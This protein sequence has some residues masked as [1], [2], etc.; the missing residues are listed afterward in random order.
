MFEI[1]QDMEHGN[2]L[3]EYDIESA[4]EAYDKEYFNFKIDDIEK[5][6]DVRIERNKR[7]HRKQEEHLLRART[8]QQL[9]Y[10]NGEW[11]GDT[12]KEQLVKDYIKNHPKENPTQIAKALNISRPTVYKYMK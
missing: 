9:D 4:L 11:R 7:N 6:T 3:T 2:P 12:S 8:V 10:P 1:L 5:L